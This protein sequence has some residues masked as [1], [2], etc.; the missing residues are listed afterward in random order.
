MRHRDSPRSEITLALAGDTMLG[1]GVADALAR[2]PARPVIA[3]EVAEIAAESDL[4]ILNL[5][6]CISERGSPWPD[7]G[8]AFFFRAPPHAAEMLAL[9]GVDC[10]TLANNHALDFGAEA[11]LDTI[12]HLRG[13]G[14]AWVG[15]GRDEDEAR[16]GRVLEA[17][18]FRLG[19]V[20][21]SDHPRDFAAAEDRPGIA[22]ADLRRSRAVDW[23][24]PGIPRTS[25]TA[26]ATGCCTTSE[27]S[28]T[29]TAWI[30]NC[31]MTSACCSS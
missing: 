3:G 8:K 5:E 12:D 29:T 30:R 14:I 27:T 18:G 6:C 9:L 21:M 11:L 19:L 22:F 4:F 10:V 1:R 16:A 17:A 23:L 28:S 25:S 31:A 20:G 15:A 2:D 7:P 26:S 13:A 24:P